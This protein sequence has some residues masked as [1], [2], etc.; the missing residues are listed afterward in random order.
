MRSGRASAS[1]RSAKNE[2]R[3]NTFILAMLGQ[4]TICSGLYRR[5]VHQSRILDR[6]RETA[7]RL[8][9]RLVEDGKVVKDGMR[10]LRLA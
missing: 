6:L 2:T 1:T 3:W 5:F 4:V 10:R 8:W 7:P 9:E